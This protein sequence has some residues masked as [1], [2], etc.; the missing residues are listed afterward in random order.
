ML[1]VEE[2]REA[3]PGI[4][5][6]LKLD[7]TTQLFV[8]GTHI[9][10]IRPPTVTNG[11]FSGCISE[12][13]FDEGRIGLHEFKTSSPLCGGCRE[14]PTAAA[15]ASTFHFLGS[16]YA[17]ISKIPKYN[18]REFQISFHFKTFWANSTLLFA[19]NEQ[20]VGVLYVTDIRT[21]IKVLYY[22]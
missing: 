7:D 11:N 6:T 21:N 18:S 9:N 10:H 8:S 5:S 16:G 2:S 15:S 20:L 19:G 22:V 14:A 17:S 3:S 4:K 1:N 12:L 13:Y